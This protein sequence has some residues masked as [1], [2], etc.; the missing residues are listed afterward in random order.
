MFEDPPSDFQNCGS[1]LF[2]WEALN[3]INVL[4][5]VTLGLILFVCKC[6]P[7]KPESPFFSILKS[8]IISLE[9]ETLLRHRRNDSA[10]DFLPVY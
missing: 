10:S 7:G 3:P 5:A 1:A 9:K 8:C 6:V 4:K 2:S